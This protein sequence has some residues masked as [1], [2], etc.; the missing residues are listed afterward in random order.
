MLATDSG[1]ADA[2]FAIGMFYFVEELYSKAEIYLERAAR[3]RPDE[4][5][6][7]NNLAI[8]QLM[9]RRFDL[10]EKNARR[11]LELL[12]DSP[13]VKDTVRQVERARLTGETA[14]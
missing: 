10:A 9:T 8:A 7:F 14:P 3:R 6:F 11:A 12:P 13:E 1:N 4:P 2:N 5:T